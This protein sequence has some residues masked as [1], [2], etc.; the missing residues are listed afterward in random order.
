MQ[1]N[2]GL[3][4]GDYDRL[5]V[6]DVGNV[7][8]SVLDIDQRTNFLLRVIWFTGNRTSTKKLVVYKEVGVRSDGRSR[9]A[10]S[11]RGVR[12]CD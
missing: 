5:A 6:D 1:S 12:V 3:L 2:K 4:L 11:P 7:V 8:G 10:V 9:E